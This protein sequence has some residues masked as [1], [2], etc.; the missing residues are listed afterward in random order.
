MP[1]G[2][3]SVGFL[4][5]LVVV[6]VI[7][8]GVGGGVLY[9][10]NHPKVPGT[11]TTAR[12]GDNVTVNYIGI[13]GSGPQEG[14]VFDT[15][16]QSVAQDNATYPKALEYTPRNS[17]GYTP[18]PVHVGPTP[19]SGYNVSG[20]TYGGVVAGFWEGLIGLAVGHSRWINVTPNLGYGELNTSCLKTAPLVTTIPETVAYTPKAFT[21]N[22]SGVSAVGG[23]TFADPTYGWTDTVLSANASAVVVERGA[24]VGA[25]T[26][27]YGWTMLVKS[28]TSGVITLQ[29]ELTP[30][31]VG[32]VLGS[33]PNVTVCSETKFV[34][35]SV[36]LSSGT[37]VEN[38][39][40]EVV[41]EDLLF[42]VTIE[43]ILP[44]S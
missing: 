13:F 32:N 28:V 9:F 36:D 22:Y 24:T 6:V 14:K 30:A 15:S 4:T 41:G 8:A 42:D 18:L 16:I 33:V 10:Y 21:A 1:A 5:F 38:Y 12:V 19:S 31:S 29:S 25:T 7:A 44:P 20:V 40:S 3:P 2:S 37:F 34:L 39:N 35:W 23:T 27:P 17:T 26:D 43:S 11:P